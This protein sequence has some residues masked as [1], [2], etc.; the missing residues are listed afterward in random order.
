MYWGT[1]HKNHTR[2][3]DKKSKKN[4]NITGSFNFTIIGNLVLRE[5]IVFLVRSHVE[6][7][8]KLL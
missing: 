7:L 5:A 4:I 6:E 3:Q 1:Q 8:K 2:E